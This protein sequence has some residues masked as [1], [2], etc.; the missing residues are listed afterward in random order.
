[1]K[2]VKPIIGMVIGTAPKVMREKHIFNTPYI[3]AITMLGGIPLLLPVT[4]DIGMAAQYIECIDGLLIPGGADVTPGLYGQEPAPQTT[5]ILEDQDA[6]ECKL[7]RM[8]RKRSIPTFGICR[9]MQLMNVVFGGTLCQDIP[10]QYTSHIAHV[11]DMSIRS[12]PTHNVNVVSGSL[13]ERLLGTDGLRVNSYHHQA[14]KKVADGFIVSAIAP[15]GVI[16]AMESTDKKMYAVQ[17]HPE[18]LVTRYERFRPLFTY[19][20]EQA[21]IK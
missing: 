16:E 18:E 20:M 17:W 15:D 11:Q 6:L 21:S 12:Q 13:V 2:G 4:G 5:Y 1:M 8:A 9:G 10:T 14:V 3:D 19:L 7:I